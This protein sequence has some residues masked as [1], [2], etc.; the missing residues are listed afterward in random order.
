MSEDKKIKVE[1][2]PGA[3]DSFEGT[4][5]ELD[6]MIAEITRMVESGE[7]V[8][9]G[10]ELTEEEWDALP[11]DVKEQIIRSYEDES[12]MIDEDDYDGDFGIDIPQRKLQ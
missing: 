4:Q 7:M 10:Q 3:F 8:E 5:E 12:S 2:A 9:A 11:D 6:E 1:F